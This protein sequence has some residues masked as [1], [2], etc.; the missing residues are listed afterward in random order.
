M[1]HI[2]GN[3]KKFFVGNFYSQEEVDEISKRTA[4]EAA[5]EERKWFEQPN[6]AN[7]YENYADDFYVFSERYSQKDKQELDLLYNLKK[8]N[9]KKLKESERQRF[10]NVLAATGWTPT[11]LETAAIRAGSG[12]DLGVIQDAC[13]KKYVVD[14]LGRS[15]VKNFEYFTVGRDTRV[16]SIVGDIDNFLQEFRNLNKMSLREK[17]MVRSCFIEGEYFLKF[18]KIEDQIYLRK[19]IPANISEVKTAQDDYEQILG[20][21]VKKSDGSNDT[22]F[23]KDINYDLHSRLTGESLTFS[24]LSANKYIQF[25]KIGEEEYLRGSPPMYPVLR[26]L[27]YYEDWLIDR[28]RL[29]HER[30]KVVWIRTRTG[31]KR[32]DLGNPFSAPKGGI[33]LDETP[34]LKYRIESAKLDAT[35]AKEDGLAI[36][37]M[38]GSGT[39]MPIHVLN[40]R[41]SEA[42]YASIRKSES[43][44]TQMIEDYQEFWESHWET[45]YRFALRFSGK[46]EGKTFKIPVYR[47]EIKQNAMKKVNE[48]VLDQRPDEEIIKEAKEI[49]KKGFEKMEKVGIDKVPITITFPQVVQEDPL[50]LAKVLYLHKKMGIVSQ[51]TA[52][53]RAGYNW[54]SEL[55]KGAGEEE[56]DEKKGGDD[57][58]LGFGNDD[59]D[60]GNDNQDSEPKV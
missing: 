58:G 57:S 60:L 28:I 9:N 32:Q 30:A 21:E 53:E 47:E 24:S 3:L 13:F 38:I 11:D 50:I 40:Q 19:V 31:D 2:W 48:M 14:P 16:N 54:Q 25:I 1:K 23:I 34:N 5:N 12:D 56:K 20:Y 45:M 33:M 18:V 51:Q 44:F 29:N 37:Y 15:I 10:I 6:R 8:R 39:N 17:N 52:S 7:T 4:I 46:F 49:L 41:T 43:P 26:Y 35:D 22:Y 55:M 42:V 59:N 36:L 27:R